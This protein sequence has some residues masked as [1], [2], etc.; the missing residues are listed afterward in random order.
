M[1]FLLLLFSLWADEFLIT[2]V[3]GIFNAKGKAFLVRK[4]VLLAAGEK[5]KRAAF[6]AG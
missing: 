4:R 2:C 5:A 3:T 1:L 6:A